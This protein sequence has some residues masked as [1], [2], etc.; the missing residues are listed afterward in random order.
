MTDNSHIQYD[1]EI[2]K[3]LLSFMISDANAF[4]LSQNIIKPDYF[5]SSIR[6]GV[7]TILTYSAEYKAIPT[8]EQV[9]ALSGVSIEKFSDV[10]SQHSDWFLKTIEG[11]CRYKALE[12][13]I[14]EGPDMLKRGE[15]ADVEKKVKEAMTI[16]LMSDLG[17]SYFE[18]PVKRL[19]RVKDRSDFVTTG[20]RALDDKLYGGFTKGALNVFAGGSGSGKSLFLQNIGLSWALMGLNVVYFSLELSED[21]VSLRIDSMTSG[22][23]TKEILTHINEVAYA[24]RQR[25]KNSGDFLIKKMPEA[26]TTAND[27]RAYLKEY[28]IQTGR[29]PD[30]IIIDYLDLMHPNNSKIDPG[31]LFTKDKYTSEEMR[32]LASEMD[33]LCVTA[34]QLNRQSVEA[35]EFDHSHIAGG[36]SKINTADNVFGIFTTATMRESGKYQLQFLKTRSSA[37]VGQKID[38]AF[39]VKSLRITDPDDYQSN[40]REI[41]KPKSKEQIQAELKQRL[42]TP[43][44]GGAP[45]MTPVTVQEGESLR[46]KMQDMIAKSRSGR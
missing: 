9:K 13:I 19:E 11:F 12:L 21:L 8:P 43:A 3:V 15:G 17:T 36:I 22:Y 16:S 38:L 44:L 41:A 37:A 32:A 29:K 2:Q 33:C 27:L 28:E 4:A 26:G 39:D 5:D 20:W 25:S 24:V 23:G 10:S 7:R 6:E 42:G 46:A 34:S 14:I 40:G 1:H 31:N 45:N 30:A 35:A 18:D